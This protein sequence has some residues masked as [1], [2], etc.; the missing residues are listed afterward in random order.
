VGGDGNGDGGD[1]ERDDGAKC[2]LHYKVKF[3]Y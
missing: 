2:T 1:D 3:Y